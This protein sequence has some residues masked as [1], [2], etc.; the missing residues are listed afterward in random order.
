MRLALP[1]L[2]VLLLLLVPACDTQ[3][4]TEEFERDASAP[5]SGFTRT[6]EYGDVISEDEDDWRSA[7]IFLGKV[8]VDPAYPNPVGT[9]VVTVPVSVLEFGG[10]SGALRLRARDNAGH[11]MIVDE[12]LD[13]SSP[14]AFVFQFSPVILAQ[15][16][17]VRLFVLDQ[18]GEL[19]SYGD[20][21]IQ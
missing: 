12:I 14:G 4:Q 8:R 7:P 18:R 1:I 3:K 5:P 19:V 13:A 11:L 15:T 16:G 20:L 9:S 17:L 2:A 10:V 6:D 21:R